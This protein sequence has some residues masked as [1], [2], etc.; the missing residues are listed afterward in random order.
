MTIVGQLMLEGLRSDVFAVKYYAAAGLNLCAEDP[1][2]CG[3]WLID[4]LGG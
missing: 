2:A 3:G 1:G 4:P